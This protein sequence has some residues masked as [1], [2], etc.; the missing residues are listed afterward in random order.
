MERYKSY[1]SKDS[2]LRKFFLNQSIDLQ[3]IDKHN[4]NYAF[5]QIERL[6]QNLQGKYK[7]PSI[8]KRV[9]CLVTLSNAKNGVLKSPTV[10]CGF[11]S[12]SFQPS[13]D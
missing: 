12:L 2:I 3:P 6:I 8:A 4:L 1:R 13:G 7:G 11:A 10:N 9:F 5:M